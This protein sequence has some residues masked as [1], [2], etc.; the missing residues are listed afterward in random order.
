MSDTDRKDELIAKAGGLATSISPERD[1][2][3]GIAEGITERRRS[4]FAPVLVQAAAVVLLVGASSVLTYLAMGG[5]KDPY[6]VITPELNMAP[7]SF[8]QRSALG[9]KYQQARIDMAT[10]LETELA[11]LDP[12]TRDKVEKNLA[13]IR[14]SID[15]I[16]KAL[17][18][19]PDNVLLQEFL[20][21]AYQDELQLMHRVGGLTQHVMARTDI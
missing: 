2:W 17:I 18:D 3:P 7:V 6:A 12:E 11:R 15:E 4:R 19:E 8:A 16:N 14:N 1:L 13:M 5:D 9:P 10:Q 21:G 20:L